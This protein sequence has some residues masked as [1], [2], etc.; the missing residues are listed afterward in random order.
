[1]AVAFPF[2]PQLDSM[3]CGS[4][5]LQT[6]FAYYNPKYSSY[7]SSFYKDYATVRTP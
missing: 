5:C 7:N 3:D 6:I 4:T 2:I 1:M